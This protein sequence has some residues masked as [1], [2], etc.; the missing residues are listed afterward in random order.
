MHSHLTFTV[1]TNDDDDDDGVF[2]HLRLHM[3]PFVKD[4]KF[5][6]IKSR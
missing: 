6:L 1:D 5:I 4:S 3:L 2:I